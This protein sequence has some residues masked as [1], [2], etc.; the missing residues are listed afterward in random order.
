MLRDAAT[1]LDIL[2]SAR[3]I[4]R[5]VDD[6]TCGDLLEDVGLQDQVARRFEIIGEAAGRLSAETTEDLPDIPWRSLVGLRNI[7]IHDYGEVD[8]AKLWDI[9]QNDL[10]HLVAEIEPL[11]PPPTDFPE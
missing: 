1:L 5:Y 2:D 10:P 4:L 6:R 7:L 8:Y 11:V 3:L 9:I